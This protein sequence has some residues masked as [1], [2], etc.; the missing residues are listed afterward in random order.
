MPVLLLLT[1]LLLTLSGCD[2]SSNRIPVSALVADDAWKT[3]AAGGWSADAGADSEL[4]K[5]A[6]VIKAQDDKEP[7]SNIVVDLFLDGVKRLSTRSSSAGTF[8][9][10][11]IPP[12]IYDIITN[13]DTALFVA[14]HDV[15]NVLADGS[16]SPET[17]EIFLETAHSTEPGTV[18]FPV[19]GEI[20]DERTG[21]TLSNEFVKLVDASD[22]TVAVT[23]SDSQGK[24]VFARTVAG[25][26]KIVAAQNSD[27]YLQ[28]SVTIQVADNGNVA[29]YPLLLLRLKT[30]ETIVVSGKLSLS[31]S[32]EPIGGMTVS[33]YR[34]ASKLDETLSNGEGKF[35]FEN[36]QAATY[37]L[38]IPAS[39]RFEAADYVVTILSDGTVS[40]ALADIQLI[41]KPLTG[42]VYRIA[43]KILDA[44]SGSPLDFVTCSL[45]EI[46][47]IITD[48][49]GNFYFESLVPG[50]YRLDLTKSG[51]SHQTVN[52]ALTDSGE[53]IP[54]SL[55][56]RLVYNQEQGKGSIVGRVVDSSGAGVGGK[57]IKVYALKFTVRIGNEKKWT[58]DDRPIKETRS[59][60]STPAGVDYSEIGAFKLTH[61]E[62]TSDDMKYLVYVGNNDNNIATETQ[63]VY[64]VEGDF[65]IPVTIVTEDISNSADR[66]CSW[67][68]VNVFADTST[69]LTNYEPH[70]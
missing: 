6:G 25:T 56:F 21:A 61:L 30:E 58:L 59:N 64:I 36:L 5:I 18:V 9:F 63:T 15:V 67:S 60:S 37:I 39:E 13:V 40:P 57:Y 35:F 66:F 23:Q 53:T 11:Q 8:V 52:F 16:T 49:G 44:Y 2:R 1:L 46:G 70:N 48:M 50:N 55:T 51:F 54:A 32:Q 14:T 27:K 43:G 29:P 65:L 24:F 34:G 7:V 62:P 20:R 41:A 12:G 4:F 69:Y 10:E 26:Y 47:P 38:K 68:E 31:I 28:F 33:L 17:L 42:T 19:S 3:G 45:Q 22:L